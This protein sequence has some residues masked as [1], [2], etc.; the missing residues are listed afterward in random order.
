MPYNTI[1]VDSSALTTSGDLLMTATPTSAIEDR[2]FPRRFYNFN[3]IIANPFATSELN[4]RLVL[5]D[6]AS[7]NTYALIDRLNKPV[8]A[9]ELQRYASFRRCIACQFDSVQNTI[10]VLSCLC[11]S[12]KFLDEWDDPTTAKDPVLVEVAETPDGTTTI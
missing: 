8:T 12:E 11:P 7:V 2:R 4:A 6:N 1:I 9:L 3:L 5:T 10:R